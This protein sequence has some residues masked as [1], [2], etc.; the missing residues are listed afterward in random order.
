[1]LNAYLEETQPFETILD[2]YRFGCSRANEEDLY[3]GHG[4]DN[5]ADD[6]MALILGSL[7]LPYQIDTHML[8]ARLTIEEKRFLASQLAKRI[9]HKIPVPYLTHDAIF[10]ELSFYVDERVLIPRSP[11]AELIKQRFSPWVNADKVLS[12]LDLCTGSGCIAI[13]CCY[14]FPEA[15][16]DAIDISC[17]ALDV[18]SI[19]RD[20]HH[21]EDRLTF[22]ESNCFDNVPKARYDIIVS[23]PPYV[24]RDEMQM[25]PVE[26]QHEPS[27]ALEAEQNGLH[28]IEKIL[29]TAADYLNDDGILVV[30]VGNSEDA[31]VHAY[32]M[33]PFVWLDFE[34]GGQ[35]V[36]LLTARDVKV[37]F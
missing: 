12:I 8:Q 16:V 35:G 14:A 10:C 20:N 21:L 17:E 34:H 22:I 33:V 9:L 25:L 29:C 15:S 36:F 19:N 27:L 28:I 5:S 31:L 7:S 1:M 37:H 26:Y 13:A 3:F 24:G 18:A 6:I 2:F 32:P 23:N 30:E 4:T 11:I